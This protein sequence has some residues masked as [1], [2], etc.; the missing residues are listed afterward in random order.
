MAKPPP[1][2]RVRPRLQITRPLALSHPN[3]PSPDN[4][5]DTRLCGT[6]AHYFQRRMRAKLRFADRFFEPRRSASVHTSARSP[7]HDN[8]PEVGSNALDVGIV[9]V[10]VRVWFE[11]G[12][13]SHVER[14]SVPPST[15]VSSDEISLPH[16][17]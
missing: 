16:A 17:S 9:C 8:S 10:T 3:H 6:T 7:T 4:V 15:R 1:P 14:L 12:R 11:R 2:W 5:T 13:R